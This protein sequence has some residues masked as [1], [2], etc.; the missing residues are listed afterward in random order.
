MPKH[1]IA[2]C[3]T[4]SMLSACG[5]S[6][7]LA[8]PDGRNRV[9]INS[10]VT[11]DEY[12]AAT[13]REAASAKEEAQQRQHAALKRDLAELKA[14]MAELSLSQG[15]LPA[16]ATNPLLAQATAGRPRSAQGPVSASKFRHS[17]K[18]NIR[19]RSTLFT[20]TLRVGETRFA[21][22]VAFQQALLAAATKATRIQ[23]RGGGN[24]TSASA[25]NAR[26]AKARREN[27][28]KYLLDNGIAP[29]RITT[30][31][32]AARGTI[33]DDPT[34]QGKARNGRV[35]IEVMTPSTAASEAKGAMQ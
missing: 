6:P 29:I 14:V 21:P 13:A 32:L 27:A 15:E 8:M 35:E 16:A 24:G 7:K 2:M 3:F 1:L 30:T 19:D 26:I 33:A 9:P 34:L 5:T 25:E 20:I 12:T 4:A 23:I 31:Y 10:Q 18:I 17:E 11:I 28:R 22:S